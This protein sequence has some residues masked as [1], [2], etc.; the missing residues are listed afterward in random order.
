VND[1]SNPY[2]P[3]GAAVSD[4]VSEGPR[5]RPLAVTIAVVLIGLRVMWAWGTLSLALPRMNERYAGLSIAL[6]AIASLV[7]IALAI[8]IARGR[9]WARR[10]FLVLAVFGVL[11]PLVSLIA[12]ISLSLSGTAALTFVGVAMAVVPL[13]L[14][15]A[16]VVLL[17]VPGREWFYPAE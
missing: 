6:T 16:I 9:N 3:P 4:P 5:T 8:F 2:L 13:V 11:V 10:V 15:I 14:M 1:S 17:C 12:T 7:A